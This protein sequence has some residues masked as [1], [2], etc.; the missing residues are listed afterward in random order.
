M[1]RRNRRPQYQ[2]KVVFELYANSQNRNTSKAEDTYE[3]VRSMIDV[4]LRKKHVITDTVFVGGNIHDI[5]MWISG[6][7]EFYQ[8]K[9][10]DIQDNTFQYDLDPDFN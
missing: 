4:M 5:S 9:D 1:S 7:I 8:Y 6:I 3:Y 2:E 10:I